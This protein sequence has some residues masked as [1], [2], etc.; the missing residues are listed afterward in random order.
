KG[1]CP[2]DPRELG[3]ARP[4][5]L[6]QVNNICAINQNLKSQQVSTLHFVFSENYSPPK[7]KNSMYFFAVNGNNIH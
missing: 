7:R 2:L 3:S 4:A 6:W 5:N 1:L